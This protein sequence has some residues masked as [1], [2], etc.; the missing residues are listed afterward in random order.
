MVPL[1]L[2]RTGLLFCL[3]QPC[4]HYLYAR[5]PSSHQHKESLLRRGRECGD[6]IRPRVSVNVVG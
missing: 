5:A 3:F 6:L 4:A 1:L 2:L